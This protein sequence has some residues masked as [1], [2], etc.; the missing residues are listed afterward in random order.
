MDVFLYSSKALNAGRDELEDAINEFLA[1]KGFVTGAGAG[2]DG[3]NIDIEIIDGDD[4]ETVLNNLKIFLRNWP[5][6]DDAYLDV[7][8][9]RHDLH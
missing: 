9:K 4:S 6:P 2:I 1:E 3:W 7:N 8:G 5:V